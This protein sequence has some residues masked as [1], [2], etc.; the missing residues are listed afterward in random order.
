MRVLVDLPVGADR[1]DLGAVQ[2]QA[3]HSL[4]EGQIPANE[5]ADAAGAVAELHVP[6]DEAVAIAE[7]QLLLALEMHLAVAADQLALR[8]DQHGRVVEDALHPLLQHHAKGDVDVVVVGALGQHVDAVAG[9]VLGQLGEARAALVACG[10]QFRE[11]DQVDGLLLAD[12]LDEVGHFAQIGFGVAQGGGHLDQR[13]GDFSGHAVNSC[14][15]TVAVRR[16]ARA[17]G[18]ETGFFRNSPVSESSITAT[19]AAPPTRLR[20]GLASRSVSSPPCL[21][22]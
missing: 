2:G 22:S 11:D 10:G 8:A 7:G 21:V 9:H 5:Q 20:S 17:V 6:D 15:G 19:P 13:D 4:G 16:P 18:E 14:R 12:A 3:A 1:H